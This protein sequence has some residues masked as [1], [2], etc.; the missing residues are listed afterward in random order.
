MAWEWS[1]QVRRDALGETTSSP[2][3]LLPSPSPR[4]SVTTAVAGKGRQNDFCESLSRQG[5]KGG[6]MRSRW[7]EQAGK[8]PA[9]ATIP[10]VC[11][12][13]AIASLQRPS[14]STTQKQNDRQGE[15]RTPHRVVHKG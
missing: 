15:N 1:H 8:Q 4:A 3:V 12:R 7:T 10:A 14:C 9:A 5:H 11:C 13:R 6:R 2:R